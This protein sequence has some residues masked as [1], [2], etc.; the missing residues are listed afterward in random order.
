MLAEAACG[1]GTEAGRG[2]LQLVEGKA[3]SSNARTVA[4]V[5]KIRRAMGNGRY[6]NAGTRFHTL[7]FST[8]RLARIPGL[9]IEGRLPTASGVKAWRKR[10]CNVGHQ[11]L[12]AE[13]RGI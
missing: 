12:A 5:R 8:A 13:P 4:S 10:R 9:V 3:S 2:R 7:N 11:A 6:A 1:R